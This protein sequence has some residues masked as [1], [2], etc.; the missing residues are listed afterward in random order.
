M[1]KKI[2]KFPN[3]QELYCLWTSY[4]QR[5]FCGKCLSQCVALSC[6]QACLLLSSEGWLCPK[7][8]ADEYLTHPRSVSIRLL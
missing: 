3:F 5:Q 7:H 8:N 2:I 6:A 4:Q 1:Q